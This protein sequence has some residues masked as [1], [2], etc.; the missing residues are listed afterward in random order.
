[1][2][3]L[4][5]ANKLASWLCGLSWFFPLRDVCFGVWSTM[6]LACRLSV[7]ALLGFRWMAMFLWVFP[8]FREGPFLYLALLLGQLSALWFSGPLGGSPSCFVGC[9]LRGS[10]CLSRLFLL[11]CSFSLLGLVAWLISRSLPFTFFVDGYLACRNLLAL[12]P[13]SPVRYFDVR[14]MWCVR[15]NVGKFTI[16]RSEGHIHQAKPHENG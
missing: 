7:L 4:G 15:V 11:T 3:H 5:F 16:H 9:C 8:P 10:F 1:M 2:R 6:P 13:V 14:Q 12:C